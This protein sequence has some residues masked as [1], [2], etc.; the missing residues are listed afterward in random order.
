MLDFNF[1][2]WLTAILCL[3]YV[4]ICIS[5]QPITLKTVTVMQQLCKMN[6]EQK[7]VDSFSELSSLNKKWLSPQFKLLSNIVLLLGKNAS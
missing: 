1:G 5:G 6:S 4:Y 3:F 7:G 2:V